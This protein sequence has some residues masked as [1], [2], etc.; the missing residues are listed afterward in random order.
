[1]SARISGSRSHQR[2]ARLRMLSVATCRRSIDL[3]LGSLG[4]RGDG[5]GEREGRSDALLG[6]DPDA[7]IVLFHDVAGDGEAQAGAAGL[8]AD[9][10][11]VD[12]V[13]ALEDARLRRLAG[14]R[15]RGRRRT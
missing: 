9:A 11:P 4:V 13:E 5:Q 15:R 8:A 1:M 6:L 14:C 12:L 2:S 3:P 7:S 10:R